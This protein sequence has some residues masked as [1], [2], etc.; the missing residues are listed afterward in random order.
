MIGTGGSG[1]PPPADTA[2]TRAAI[3]AILA[4][5]AALII[6]HL[7]H[8]QLTWYDEGF[9]AVVAGNLR[10]HLLAF[11][12]Y[13]YDWLNVPGSPWELGSLWLHK[14]PLALWQMALALG[15]FG[16][17]TFALRLPSLLY[18]LGGTYIIYLLSLRLFASQSVGLIAAALHAFNPFVIGCVLGYNFSDHVDIALLFWTEAGMLALAMALASGHARHYA[19]FGLCVGL[20]FLSKSFPALITMGVG[21]AVWIAHRI[22][23]PSARA[24]RVRLS[25]LALAAFVAALPVGLWVIFF[26]RWFGYP[27]R[28]EIRGW[29]IHLNANIEGWGAPWDRYFF[30]YMI[31]HS[32]WLYVPI[33][34]SLLWLTTRA[35]RGTLGE[36]FVVLWTWGTLVPLTIA[37]S[38]MPSAILVATPALLV[39]FA[40]VAIEAFYRQRRLPLALMIG[41]AVAIVAVRRGTSAVTHRD[42]L[43]MDVRYTAWTYVATNDWVVWQALIAIGVA[44]ALLWWWSHRW[45]PTSIWHRAM[46]VTAVAVMLI[47]GWCYVGVAFKVALEPMQEPSMRQLGTVVGERYGPNTVFVMDESRRATGNFMSLMFWSERDVYTTR[48]LYGKTLQTV[49]AKIRSNGGTPILILDWEIPDVPA[50]PE[51]DARFHLYPASPI[52]VEQVDSSLAGRR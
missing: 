3:A 8:E 10:H 1:S 36:L 40:Y 28:H 6:S 17:N 21:G 5:S 13:S 12:L 41:A 48:R 44:T 22:G 25:G 15:A 9:H 4:V 34:L 32:P 47:A 23:L 33:L 20:G 31:A 42:M 24:A 38:K 35:M 2:I 18:A 45:A 50:L 43:A 26:N 30:D 19:I 46:R 7:G 52:V 16:K 29:L 39:A 49:V 37:T 27:F 11:R 14:P 51:S